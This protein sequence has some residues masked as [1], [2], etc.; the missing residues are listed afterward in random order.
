LSAVDLKLLIDGIVRQ[1]T[2]LIAQL[3]TSAGARAPLSHVADQVFVELAQE[4][5]AQG[6]RRHRHQRLSERW[7]PRDVALAGLGDRFL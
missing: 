3:S 2:I 4:I 6:V 5:E 1:T 7:P